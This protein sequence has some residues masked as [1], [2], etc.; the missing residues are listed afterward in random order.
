VLPPVM[1]MFPERPRHAAP[2]ASRQ[3]G[4][5]AARGRAP[6]AADAFPDEL[7][8]AELATIVGRVDELH[9]SMTV[10]R[11]S[12]FA[13]PFGSSVREEFCSEQCHRRAILGI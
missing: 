2:A 13:S 11:S 10:E 6:P 3:H 8:C 12:I 7:R 9:L 1:D 4:A 5:S